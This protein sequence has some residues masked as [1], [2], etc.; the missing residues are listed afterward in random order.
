MD[1]RAALVTAALVVAVASVASFVA[2]GAKRGQIAA[3][4]TK[5]ESALTAVL[6]PE[7]YLGTLRGGRLAGQ[8]L[9]EGTRRYQMPETVDR[10]LI[11]MEGDWLAADEFI[12]STDAHEIAAINYHAGEVNLV[13]DRTRKRSTYAVIELDGNPVPKANWGPDIEDRDGETVV[14]VDAADLYHLIANGPEGDHILRIKPVGAGV[15]L[16]AF[17]FGQ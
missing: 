7:T 2:A 4:P 1:R 5:A 14:H 11:G 6:T 3:V 17:R 9:Q 12:E 16:Y 15:Q 13:M 10:G 8:E